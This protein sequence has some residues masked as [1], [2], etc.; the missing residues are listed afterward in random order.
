MI[1]YAIV[2]PSMSMVGIGSSVP[3]AAARRA[4]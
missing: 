3:V 4:A 2:V 1:S